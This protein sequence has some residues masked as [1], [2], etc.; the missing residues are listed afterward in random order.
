[1]NV[2]DY[3]NVVRVERRVAFTIIG[4]NVLEDQKQNLETQRKRRKQRL[5]GYCREIS[6]NLSGLRKGLANVTTPKEPPLP[7]RFQVY[8]FDFVLVA[9]SSRCVSR[10]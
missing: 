10:F 2:K 6:G 3:L 1:L 7:L 5:L 8:G 9:A 4:R